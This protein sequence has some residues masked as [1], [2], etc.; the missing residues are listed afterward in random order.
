VSDPLWYQD[1]IVYQLRV[2]SFFDSDD[3]GVGDFSGLTSKLDYLQDLGV[4]TLWLL[5]FYPSPRR[6]D[7]YDISDYTSVHPEYGTLRDFK[8]FLR[9][10]HRR[11]LRVVTELV[12]NHTSD[13][14]AWFQRARRAPKGS[15]WRDFYVW[16]DDAQQYL[17]A[18]I[19]FTD[20]ESSNWTWDPVAGSHF[21]HR[22]FHHQPDLNFD[23]PEVRKALFRV[24]DFWFGMGVDGVRLDAVPYLYERE[25]TSCEN[26]PET[27]AFLREL[28][29]HIDARYDDRMLLAEANQWPEDAVAYFGKGDEC[30]MAFHFPV[31]PRLFMAVHMEDRFPI[32]D[33]LEQT[34]AIP[35]S[36]QW[37]IFLRNHDELTLEMVTDEERDY[38]W[39]VYAEDRRARINL[40]IRRRLAPL[41]GN[42]RRKIE[43]MNAL[44]FS[45][46]GT[47]IVYYGDEIGMGDNHFLGDRNGVRTPMQWSPDRN[48]GFSRANPQ[49]LFLP[50][51]VDSEYHYEAV[52]VEV[53]QANPSSLLWWMKRVLTLRSRF[54]CFGRGTL[55]PLTPHNRRVLA[56]LRRFEDE[57][58]LVVAN[59]SRFSQYVELDLSEFQ[60]VRPVELFGNVPFPPIGELPYLLTLGPHGFHWFSLSDP[61]RGRDRVE[62][63]AA[64]EEAPPV[65][66]ES[67]RAL[68]TGRARAGLEARL[69]DFLTR[70]RWFRSKTRT[71]AGV[72]VV[73][74]VALRGSGSDTALWLAFVRVDFETG[75]PETYVLPLAFHAGEEP[76]NATVTRVRLGDAEGRLD[77]ASSDPRLGEALRDLVARGRSVRGVQVEVT[78]VRGGRRGG[79]LLRDA[80]ER[81]QLLGREQSNTSFRFGDR[82]VGKLLR[83]LDDGA[84]PEVEIASYLTEVAHF[85]HSPPLAGH[86]ALRRGRS[87]PA[88]LAV[89]HGH[90][91]NEGD[92]WTYTLDALEQLLE[93]ELAEGREAEPTPERSL[94]AWARAGVDPTEGSEFA[95]YLDMARLL[96]RRTGELH[97]ALAA[98]EDPA[99]AP[100]RSTP[101]GRRSHYQS[102][103]NLTARSLDALGAALP[104]FEPGE[105][106]D[107]ARAVL[108]RR[109]EIRARLGEILE[110]PGGSRIRIH[111]D[112]HLGQ[113]LFTGRDF[114]IIDFEGEPAR[115]LAERRHKRSPLV[116]VAGMLRSFHYAAEMALRSDGQGGPL[117]P[118]QARHLRPWARHWRETVSAAFLGSWLEE[119]GPARLLPADDA[120]LEAVLRV[121][122]LEK[123]LYELGYELDNRPAWVD[124]PLR[125]LLDVLGPEPP[126][127]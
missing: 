81:P 109:E 30:H 25:G 3:D 49:S 78:G 100:E 55:E 64:D 119:I 23:N 106:A 125:G 90:V 97:R 120:D 82:L 88:T 7:G 40:G 68:L 65:A 28:R 72:H 8:T 31:M 89:F 123:A 117:Q 71:L 61:E 36:C 41:M 118:E 76:W 10:A 94:L 91:P 51:V 87:E 70:Q 92:A 107:L 20:S 16:S 4:N 29:A 67:L 37:A 45:L 60:G 122:L 24:M 113:V 66:A 12:L 126:P 115:S 50:A 22:F 58:V 105:A 116:D 39:R 17:D 48:G 53:Q 43:L 101:F 112:Y 13:Q 59:L 102:L 77:E 104:G 127:S 46:N 73:D 98:G 56:F 5:P 34:P 103:R 75:T 111:G 32:L 52:N 110:R 83:R 18:R 80:A 2:P 54:R 121:H 99:F 11:G 79:R 108:D 84:S 57:C 95:F 14:H 9:E 33:I 44:L 85:D 35:D 86:V 96:G 69:P 93:T 1:A 47:P 63:S 19:I 74:A 15:R 114:Q 42:N 27:H 124:I 26:L 6:D 62:P 38:M 21:W